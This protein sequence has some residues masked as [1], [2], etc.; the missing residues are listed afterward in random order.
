MR[1]RN[2]LLALSLL[3]LLLPWSGWKLVQELENFLRQAEENS[4]LAS[5]QTLT[6]VLPQEYQA[7][8]RLARGQA[9][10]LRQL[11]MEPIADGYLTDWPEVNQNLSFESPKGLLKLELL[12]GRYGSHFYLAVKVT[13]P[14]EVRATAYNTG[15]SDV[16]QAAGVM[17]YV[18]SN[19]GQFSYMISSEAPGPL[20]LNSQG[21]NGTRLNAAWMD[22]TDGY[23]VELTLPGD[24][25]RISI[26]AV[27]PA[28]TMQGISYERYAGTLNGR[29]KGQWLELLSRDDGVSQ[30]L[31]KTV[32]EN[33]RA[34]L[35]Q[36]DGWV[37]ADSGPANNAGNSELTWVK[38]MLYQAVA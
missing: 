7:E 28:F 14:G 17:L 30:W 22:D 6:T 34:W 3:T 33:T 23:T 31:T 11:A 24:V 25:E 8:L 27:A 13:D 21:G 15:A 4:L 10:P 19:R 32:P 20:T 9:L 18:Q 37:V 5:G 1:L 2:Q 12:A 36:T 16:S 35:V 38:R 26:G 29:H